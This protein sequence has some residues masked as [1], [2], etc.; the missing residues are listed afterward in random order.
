MTKF[1]ELNQ[2]VRFI[3]NDFPLKA[4]IVSRED[5]DT[6]W[7][8]KVAYN[9]S[10]DERI[11]AWVL[12]PKK[13]TKQTSAIFCFHQHGSNWDIGKSEPVGLEGDP[14]LAYAKELTERGYIT[15]TPDAIAFEERNS[16][17][18]AGA[19]YFQLAK[20]L[21]D[22][23][24]L[25]AKVISDTIKG[26]DY[27][28]SREE[29]SGDKVGF[30]GHSYGGR[31]ALWMPVF[32]D[33]IITSVSNC[34]CVNYKNSIDERAIGV[35][36]EFVIPDILEF[37]DMEDI[38]PLGNKTNLLVSATSEDKYCV[39]A[40]DLFRVIQNSYTKTEVKLLEYDGGHIFTKEMRDNAYDFIEGH[41][42][43]E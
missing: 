16:G 19:N 39:G 35:Q 20:H 18:G 23:E 26:I 11:T 3:K 43:L 32:D 37:G 9:V 7:R 27:I 33:R 12:L 15:I 42:P 13:T 6:H 5:A 31:M 17:G 4:E 2:K 30:I 24:T 28:I 10:E 14:E 40:K 36:M 21:V 38:I 29:V 41:L 22:G 8:E 1:E 34:G 25:L